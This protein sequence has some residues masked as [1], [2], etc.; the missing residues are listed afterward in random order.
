MHPFADWMADTLSEGAKR[1]TRIKLENT[2]RIWS[3]EKF[4]QDIA[5]MHKLCD[6]VIEDRKK[7]P[8]PDVQD[9]LSTMLEGRI[10]GVGLSDE[11]IK[12]QMGTFM[13]GL[14]WW[15]SKQPSLTTYRLPATKPPVELSVFSSTR[16]SKTQRSST[17]HSVKSMKS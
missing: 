15:H 1:S 4:K 8:R 14:E 10:D 16:S 5:N 7:N 11:N 3:A 12:Y 13:V 2:A 6:E 9:L 17:K